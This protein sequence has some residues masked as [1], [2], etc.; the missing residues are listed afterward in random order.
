MHTS[1]FW[2][3]VNSGSWWWTGRPGV[4]RFMGPQRVGH[5]WETELKGQNYAPLNQQ[6]KTRL[7]NIVQREQFD[8]SYFMHHELVYWYQWKDKSR[9][10]K[11]MNLRKFNC[12]HS[13][14]AFL[15]EARSL[16]RMSGWLRQRTTTYRRESHEHL[17]FSKRILCYEQLFMT[18][19]NGI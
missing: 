1:R 15:V 19:R 11:L 10:C 2:V 14:L 5:D 4:L 3:W 9:F 6:Y 7:F 16:V 8:I 12:V 18:S 17:S 13:S